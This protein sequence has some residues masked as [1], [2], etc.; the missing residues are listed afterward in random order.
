[1][2]RAVRALPLCVILPLSGCIITSVSKAK[3]WQEEVSPGMT[4][5]AV[6]E[7]LGEPMR[8]FPVPGQGE[9]ERLPVEILRYYWRYTTWG[10]VLTFV[11]FPFG[12]FFSDDTPHGFDI[13][14]DQKGKVNHI[15]EVLRYRKG[16]P[17][18]RPR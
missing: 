4:K 15:S 1:M 18:G 12:A 17:Q 10:Y 16:E 11:F 8:S 14:F 9:D 13:G 7:S 5:A 3:S 2:N 6:R